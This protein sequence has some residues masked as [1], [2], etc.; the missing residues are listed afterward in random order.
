M[1]LSTF[2]HA[3]FHLK[4][5]QEVFNRVTAATFDVLRWDIFF[6]VTHNSLSSLARLYQMHFCDDLLLIN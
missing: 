5:T 3:A 2:I 4:H 1:F 6:H